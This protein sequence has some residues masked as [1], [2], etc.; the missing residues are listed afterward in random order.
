MNFRV[1]LRALELDDYRTSVKWRNDDEIV[2]MVGGPKYFV[3]SERE[4]R[5]VEGKALADG[6]D[7]TL[8]VC[9]RETGK[10]I[11]NASLNEVDYV[12]RSGR[13]PV[14][15]GDKS[16]WGKGLATEACLLIHR[17]AFRDRGLERIFAQVLEN[18]AASL[19]MYE[20]CGYIREGLLRHAVYKNGRFQNLVALSVLRVEFD[21]VARKLG[22]D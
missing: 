15:I 16:E 17:F 18:N 2:S 10:Y 3:S 11:G 8:A 22:L 14:L 19:K 6:P 12:N 9:I 1:Y 4:R 21:V 7:T 5:W 13:C 20:K